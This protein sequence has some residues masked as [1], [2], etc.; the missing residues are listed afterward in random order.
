MSEL[1]DLLERFRRGAELIATAMTGAAGAELDF[2]PAPEKW[3]LRQIV[4]HA[5]AWHQAHPEGYG[6]SSL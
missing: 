2:T 6:A 1:K 3:S 4:A 5:W